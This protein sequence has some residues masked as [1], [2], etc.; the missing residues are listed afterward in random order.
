MS[1]LDSYFARKAEAV[2]HLQG[3]FRANPA[4]A[5]VTLTATSK[6]AGITGA[7][8]TRMGDTVVISDSGPGLAGHALGPTA[9]EILLGAL[10][11]CL[12]HTYLL[13]AVLMNIAIDHVE[14]TT[15]GTLDYAAV[16]GLPYEQPPRM[17]NITYVAQV[18]TSESPEHIKA[19]HAAVESNCPVLNTLRFP[20]EVKYVEAESVQ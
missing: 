20:I 17:E 11:S 16:V 13:Q 8:P 19:L 5:V 10:A 14:V 7:R 4:A 15:S 3:D 6:V 1:K 9:P 18:E 12:V 2:A